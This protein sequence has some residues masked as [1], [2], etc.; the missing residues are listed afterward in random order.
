MI[1]RT[2]SADRPLHGGHVPHWLSAR[3]ARGLGL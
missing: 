2:G 1:R 3:M